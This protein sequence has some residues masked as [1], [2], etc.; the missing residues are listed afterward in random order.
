MHV[1]LLPSAKNHRAYLNILFF[2]NLFPLF[3][4]LFI[5]IHCIKKIPLT[6]HGFS[7]FIFFVF[8]PVIC[9]LIFLISTLCY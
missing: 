5:Y 6:L 1:L 9:F 4:Y 7:L 3:I 2:L 8:A